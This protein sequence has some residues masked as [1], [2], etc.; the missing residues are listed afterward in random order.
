[1]FKTLIENALKSRP[2]PQAKPLSRPFVIAPYI[3]EL[4]GWRRV[5]AWIALPLLTLFCLVAGFFY[6]LTTPYLIPQFAAPL[7][8]VA[9][10][11]V[12]ALPDIRRAPTRPLGFLFFAF[13]YAA[14]LWPNY[15]AIVP[16]GLPWITAIRLIG[17]PLSFMLLICV[18]VSEDFR[19]ELARILRAIPYLWKLVGGFAII[20]VVSIVFSKHPADS[21]NTLVET[22]VSWTVMFFVAAWIFSKPGNAERW[23]AIMWIS[24]VVLCLVG[25]EEKREQHVPWAGHIPSFLQVQDEYVSRVLQG[26]RRLGTDEYRLQGTHSTSLG[27]AEYLALTTPFVIHFMME[28]YKPWIRVAAGLSIPFIFYTILGTGARL[29]MVGFFCSCLLYLLCWG[30]L[31]WR[32]V[33]G[34]ILGPAVV[35]SYPAVFCAFMAA[36]FFVQRLHNMVWGGSNTSYSNEGR[37]A[38]VAAGMPKILSHPWGYGIGMGAEALDYHNLAGVLTIDTYYLLVALDYGVLGFLVYYATIILV[39]VFAAKYGVVAP[40][41]ERERTF[42]IP[43]GIALVA[44]FIIKSIFSQTENHTLQFMMMGMVAALV[45]R[46]KTQPEVATV[47]VEVERAG[48]R[49]RPKLGVRL[50]VAAREDL[51]KA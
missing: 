8:L 18:S 37:S 30:V 46:I 2:R 5:A 24:A 26:A 28:R 41:K 7:V 45:Y 14:L 23:A 9:M 33:K 1:M 43:T 25:I 49:W 51:G 15:L 39:I 47:P 11:V 48:A 3:P 17:F 13:L 44:F 10:C 6:A 4:T 20:Q 38:Q 19:S 42:L 21:I 16:P 27:F 22:Q 36:T 31:R 34:S 29:G 40:P 50:P 35:L 32:L 12:W